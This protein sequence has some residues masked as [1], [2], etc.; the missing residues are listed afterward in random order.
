MDLSLLYTRGHIA[1]NVNDIYLDDIYRYVWF[2]PLL[3][4]QHAK[5]PNNNPTLW[6]NIDEIY[7][8]S[9]FDLTLHCIIIGMN[10]Q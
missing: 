6:G 4:F 10:S 3:R 2:M 5:N 8:I 7:S 9:A 1:F